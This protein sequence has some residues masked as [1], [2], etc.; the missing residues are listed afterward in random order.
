MESYDWD[1]DSKERPAVVHILMDFRAPQNA[2][3]F[4]T[5]SSS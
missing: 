1:H 4:L 2:G 5:G 3:N